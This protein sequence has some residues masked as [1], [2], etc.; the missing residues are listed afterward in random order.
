[1]GTQL[2]ILAPVPWL[3]LELRQGISP[4]SGR[5]LLDRHVRDLRLQQRGFSF[6]FSAAPGRGLLTNGCVPFKGVSGATSIGSVVCAVCVF[7]SDD[8]VAHLRSVHRQFQTQPALILGRDLGI[9]ELDGT[10]SIVG[11]VDSTDSHLSAVFP[12]L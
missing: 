12:H 1:M 6:V 11:W 9:P 5:P 10:L 3:S 7:S 4:A 2:A 8:S